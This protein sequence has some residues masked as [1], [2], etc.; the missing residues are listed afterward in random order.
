MPNTWHEARPDLQP[1][2]YLQ[3]FL[4][5]GHPRVE[6]FPGENLSNNVAATSH[7]KLVFRPY[8]NPTGTN[9]ISS[10]AFSNYYTPKR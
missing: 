6:I 4:N 1:L 7:H 10:H 9:R 8:N 2:T 5:G 3:P